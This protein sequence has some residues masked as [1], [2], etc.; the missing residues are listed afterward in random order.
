MSDKGDAQCKV[1]VFYRAKSQGFENEPAYVREI[2]SFTDSFMVIDCLESMSRGAGMSLLRA[3]INSF[4][5][6]TIVIQAGYLYFGDYI[7]NEYSAKLHTIPGELCSMYE[8]EGFVNINKYI[9]QYENS[10]M[11]TDVLGVLAM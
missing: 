6:E 8:G 2:N 4:T 10:V 3:V 9:G 11:V 5:Y 1:K 7:M